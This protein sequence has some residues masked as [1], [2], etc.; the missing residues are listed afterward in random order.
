MLLRGSNRGSDRRYIEKWSAQAKSAILRKQQSARAHVSQSC[1]HAFL[2]HSIPNSLSPSSYFLAVVVA[3]P[4]LMP[5]INRLPLLYSNIT[6]YSMISCSLTPLLCLW[7][8]ASDRVPS[9]AHF[10]HR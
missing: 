4:L 6:G 9:N 1:L 2:R 10:H 8:S 7:G 3:L 5:M